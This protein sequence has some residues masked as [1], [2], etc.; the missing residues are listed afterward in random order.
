MSEKYSG[1]IYDVCQSYK[2][3]V[4]DKE[5]TRLLNEMKNSSSGLLKNQLT[6]K[7]IQKQVKTIASPW[8][9]EF[10]KFDPDL[11][12]SKVK[13]PVLAM[14]G[15]KDFQVLPKINLAGIENSLKKAGNKDVT[16]ME[17]KDL[18]H[19]FQTSKTGSFSEYAT[20]EETFSPVALNIISD[21]ILKRY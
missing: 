15:E 1:K 21:W 19:L 10:I 6:G 14:N 17:L 8:M 11:Y 13:C 9:I 16:I 4:S 20:I 3:E 5:I 18:N 7:N 12:L 2:G